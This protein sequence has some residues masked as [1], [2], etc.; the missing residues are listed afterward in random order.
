MGERNVYEIKFTKVMSK[1]ISENQYNFNGSL[2]DIMK[3]IS[4]KFYKA[5][6]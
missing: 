4:I 2:K 3:M 6:F 1:G 5:K